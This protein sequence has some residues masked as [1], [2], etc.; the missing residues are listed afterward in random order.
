MIRIVGLTI[1]GVAITY[2]LITWFYFGS[3]HPCGI[4]E[5]VRRQQL[6]AMLR[7]NIQRVAKERGLVE[8]F[9]AFEAE[10]EKQLEAIKKVFSE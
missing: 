8:G 6:D 9:R 1:A 3:P 10:Q 5:T 4:Y 7:A 2:L